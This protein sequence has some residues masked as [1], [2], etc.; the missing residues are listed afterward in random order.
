MRSGVWEI[1]RFRHSSLTSWL[2]ATKKSPVTPRGAPDEAP[3]A[4]HL[5]GVGGPQ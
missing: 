5:L 2:F 3:A 4:G 1:I